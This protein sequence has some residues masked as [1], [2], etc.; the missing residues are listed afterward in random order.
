MLG[1]NCCL[2]TLEACG[3][4]QTTNSVGV[5]KKLL[6]DSSG[7]LAERFTELNLSIEPLS[8]VHDRSLFL[9]LCRLMC[10]DGSAS[11]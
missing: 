10:G 7:T 2:H 3:I 8:S 4:R 11:P 1:R 6:E 9:R 5:R